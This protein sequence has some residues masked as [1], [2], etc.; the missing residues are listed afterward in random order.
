MNSSTANIQHDAP[1]MLGFPIFPENLVDLFWQPL[2]Y[3]LGMFFLYGVY[4][5]I[6]FAGKKPFKRRVGFI[7]LGVL[8]F[9]GFSLGEFFRLKIFGV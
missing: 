4:Q 7:G 5:A 6:R 2:F 3:L 1:R 9:F 8:I